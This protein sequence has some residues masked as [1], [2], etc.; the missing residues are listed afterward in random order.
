MNRDVI[1]SK[2]KKTISLLY[3]K[4]FIDISPLPA[5]SGAIW[6]DRDI[7]EKNALT[8]EPNSIWSGARQNFVLKS[9]FSLN[10]K[11]SC[12]PV[13]VIDLG[14][15]TSLEILG[16]LYGPEAVVY[17]DG[18]E[19]AGLDPNHFE[20]RLCEEFADGKSHE[21]LLEGWTG[22]K[23][24]AYTVG[25]IAVANVHKTTRAFADMLRICV[26]VIETD[27]ESPYMI[28][29]LNDANVAASELNLSEPYGDEF[30][31][32]VET[33]FNSLS[34]LLSN[35]GYD[36]YKECIAC[37]HGHLDL[38]WLWR[39][40][41][42]VEKGTRTFLNSLRLMEQYEDFHFSQTQPQLYEWIENK[43]PYVFEQIKK[44]V[45]SGQWEVLGGLWVEPDCNITG[46]ESLVRQMVLFDQYVNAK[47]QVPASPVVWLPDTFGFC[48]QLPQLMKSAG[49]KYFAT[50]KLTWNQYDKMPSEYFRW[51]GIDGSEVTTYLVTT[52]KPAWWGATYSADL[53]PEELHSTFK[54]LKSPELNDAIA[55][56]YGMGDGGGGPTDLMV[57]NAEILLN[58]RFPDMP[59]VKKGTFLEFFESIDPNKLPVWNG[60]LYFEL[61]R[62]TYTSQAETK[63]LNRLCEVALHNAEFLCT[64]ASEETGFEYPYKELTECWKRLCLNQFHDILP[65][66]SIADVYKDAAAHYG[67]ILEKTQKMVKSAGENLSCLAAKNTDYMIFN[68]TGFRRDGFVEIPVTN[69]ENKLIYCGATKLKSA[70]LNNKLTVKVNDIPSYGFMCIRVEDKKSPSPMELQPN[71]ETGLYFDESPLGYTLDNGILRAQFDLDGNLLALTDIAENRNFIPAGQKLSWSLYEDNPADWDA[72]DV[73]E[74]YREKKPVRAETVSVIPYSNELMSGIEVRLKISNSTITANIE[75]LQ[76]AKELRYTNKIGYYEKHKLLRMEL[77]IDIHSDEAS[78]G[79]QFG[80]VKRA[81]HDNTTWQQAQFEVC[82]HK[83]MDYSEGDYGVGL[84]CDNKYGVMAKNGIISLAVL[85]SASFPD[86]H[87]DEGEHQFTFAICPHAGNTY[88]EVIKKA[89]ELCNPLIVCRAQAPTG[90]HYK[91][92][93]VSVSNKHCVL[94]TVKRQERGAGIITR[95]YEAFNTRGKCKI[96][97]SKSIDEAWSTDVLEKSRDKLTC[98]DNCSE[99]SISPYEIKNIAFTLK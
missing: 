97:T 29:L 95:L 93:F 77:P 67:F 62:G 99:F 85:K 17:I 94:E 35:N 2:L 53:S 92:G 83:W 14:K 32:S 68:A 61:H 5:L 34:Y 30:F 50:A 69:P 88:N 58:Y 60:E 8:I 38:A 73:D 20:I 74:D 54:E 64:W 63:R 46:G 81:T 98:K 40:C 49:L 19:Y 96:I 7:N 16:F 47:F 15:S 39:N 13:V 56:P 1:F 44:R 75:L 25:T 65:G 22:I 52:S 51:K 59:T 71:V 72:W 66:S 31:S 55:V 45:N 78:F 90:E 41:T 3:E 24:E 91:V 12:E 18:R 37:G 70:V 86:E 23:N 89:Y 11:N 26:E 84:I 79:T 9:S 80:S 43:H 76:G 87:A 10:K 33:A 21:L 48:G 6:D 27:K 28:R 42:S 82:M 4:S 36:N 57:R